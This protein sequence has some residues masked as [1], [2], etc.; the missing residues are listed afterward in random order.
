MWGPLLHQHPHH[1]LMH[2]PQ[3][4]KPGSATQL[5]VGTLEA[6]AGDAPSASLARA[7]VAGASIADVMVAAKMQ[8]SKGAAR[9]CVTHTHTHTHSASCLAHAVLH[10]DFVTL[11]CPMCDAAHG[12]LATLLCCLMRNTAIDVLATSHSL[13]RDIPMHLISHLIKLRLH[14]AALDV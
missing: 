11:H 14:C 5:D 10:R 6:V 1:T 12:T 7:A 9:K 3:A 13:L 2:A 4:L 8:P